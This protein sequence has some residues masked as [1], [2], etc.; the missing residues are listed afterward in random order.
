MT[1]RPKMLISD[2]LVKYNLS[3]ENGEQIVTY[4]TEVADDNVIELGKIAID[5]T[6]LENA[7]KKLLLLQL[8]MTPHVHNSLLDAIVPFVEGILPQLEG[9]L[10]S[11][12]QSWLT[13]AKGLLNLPT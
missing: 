4:F 9:P 7:D 11:S 1:G 8:L 6:I 5:A 12:L 3:V 2:N 10:Q 13:Q